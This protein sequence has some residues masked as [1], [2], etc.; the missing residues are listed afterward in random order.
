MV[1]L[2]ARYLELPVDDSERSTV[3]PAQVN[4]LTSQVDAPSAQSSWTW[5]PTSPTVTAV[6]VVAG[7]IV[8]ARLFGVK[9]RNLIIAA[10]ITGTLILGAFIIQ[11]ATDPRF[12]GG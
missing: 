1:A 5:P 9:T 11:F 12:L 10:V 6:A 2:S 3:A 7:A 4:V 8:D